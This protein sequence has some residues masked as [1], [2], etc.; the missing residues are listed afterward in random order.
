M[1]SRDPVAIG[2]Q[3]RVYANQ[4]SE[5]LRTGKYMRFDRG[6]AHP[7]VLNNSGNIVAFPTAAAAQVNQVLIAGG[8]N[9]N[10][11]ASAELFGAL[12]GTWTV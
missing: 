10:F 8:Y 5:G 12:L 11:V 2:D 9:G 4:L 6:I 1:P 7:L 3:S